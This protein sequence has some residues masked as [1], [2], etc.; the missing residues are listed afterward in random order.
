AS[1]LSRDT[2][3]SFEISPDML[4][5]SLKSGVQDN[6]RRR[7]NEDLAQNQAEM[8]PLQK[9]QRDLTEERRKLQNMMQKIEAE[10]AEVSKDIEILTQKNKEIEETIAILQQ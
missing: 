8:E 2:Q 5:A 9:K 1:E 3:S 7:L 6:I 4:K 10:E